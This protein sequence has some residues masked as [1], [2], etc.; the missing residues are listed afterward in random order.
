MIAALVAV[1]FGFLSVER[2]PAVMALALAEI[3]YEDGARGQD[4]EDGKTGTV[5]ESEA[6]IEIININDIGSDILIKTNTGSQKSNGGSLSTDDA[7]VEVE[8][9]IESGLEDNDNNG[10]D[11]DDDDRL[12][13]KTRATGTGLVIRE[14]EVRGWDDEKKREHLETV[15]SIV[16]VKTGEDLERFAQGV[17]LKDE[18]IKEV[19]VENDG[20]VSFEYRQ[21]V[22]LLGFIS[23][24]MTEDVDVEG[25]ETGEMKVK[26]KFP[27]WHVFA[28]KLVR[29]EE[30]EGELQNEIEKIALSGQDGEGISSPESTGSSQGVRTLLQQHVRVFTIISNMLKIKHDT[31]KNSINNIR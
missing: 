23:L 4:G 3:D 6:T 9:E 13:I 25:V 22:K 10:D 8:L 27:W 7:E 11:S 19:E 5:R 30:L 16:E 2:A 28:K 15:K 18:N 12:E 29:A 17:L 14:V 20:D 21:K 26:V 31:V 1:F 24:L